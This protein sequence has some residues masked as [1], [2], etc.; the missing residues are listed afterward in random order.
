MFPSDL[1]HHDDAQDGWLYTV[2]FPWPLAL[3]ATKATGPF[4]YLDFRSSG[5]V[6]VFPMM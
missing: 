4:I 3:V 5:P 6:N 1:H 2:L